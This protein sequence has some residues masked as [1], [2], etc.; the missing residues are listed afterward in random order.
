MFQTKTDQ[1]KTDHSICSVKKGVRETQKG[2]QYV[3]TKF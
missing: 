3:Q 1:K 2:E